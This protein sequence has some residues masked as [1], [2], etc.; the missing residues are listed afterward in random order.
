MNTSYFFFF[1]FE[2]FDNKRE[3]R[4]IMRHRVDAGLREGLGV[5]CLVCF[6]KIGE[7]RMLEADVKEPVKGI[8]SRYES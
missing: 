6:F 5:Y 3:K 8:D 4:D 7:T 1:F 2:K